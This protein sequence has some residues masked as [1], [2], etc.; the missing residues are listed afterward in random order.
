[1]HSKL[2]ILIA[3][4]TMAL[5]TTIYVFFEGHILEL[6]STWPQSTSP[7]VLLRI[8]LGIPV[9]CLLS[10]YSYLYVQNSNLKDIISSLNNDIIELIKKD[11]TMQEQYSILQKQYFEKRQDKIRYKKLTKQLRVKLRKL[12]K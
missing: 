7:K 6:L 1:M 5:L 12:S 3:A 9:V 11:D 10:A 8:L 4:I 2:K